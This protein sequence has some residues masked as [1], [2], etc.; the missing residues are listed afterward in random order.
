[1]Q[2]IQAGLH[3]QSFIHLYKAILF[4]HKIKVSEYDTTAF[5]HHHFNFRCVVLHVRELRFLGLQAKSL[6]AQFRTKLWQG[7]SAHFC[8]LGNDIVHCLSPLRQRRLCQSGSSQGECSTRLWCNWSKGSGA[9]NDSQKSKRGES[10]H[11]DR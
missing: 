9:A 1:M 5:L 3:S 11:D 8:L 10:G 7:L 6:G 2:W 4:F